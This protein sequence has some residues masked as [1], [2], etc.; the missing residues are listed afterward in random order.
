MKAGLAL[1]LLPLAPACVG[2]S[3]S[4]PEVSHVVDES[5]KRDLETLR[6]ARVYFGH[7]V[8]NLEKEGSTGETL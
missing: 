8:E 6:S 4:Q 1:A 5:L 2:G 3:D 7:Q